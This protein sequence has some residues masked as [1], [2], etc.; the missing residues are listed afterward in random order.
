MEKEIDNIP[1]NVSA[2]ILRHISRGI[3]RTPAGA[4]KELVSNAHDAGAKKI[5]INTDFP[6]FEKITITDNGSGMSSDNFKLIISNIGLSDK[7][8]G[9]EFTIPGTNTKRKV[10]GHYGIG[11]LAIG[12]LC[13][14]VTITSKVENEKEGFEAIIDF[15][16]FEV[17]KIDDIERASIKDETDLET[18]DK[19]L[20]EYASEK[21]KKFPI[22]KCRITK[23]K[24]NDNDKSEHFTRLELQQVR[25]FVQ[26]KLSGSLLEKYSDLY[27]EPNYSSNFAKLLQLYRDKEEDIR[28]GQYPYEKLCW[29]LAVY[30]PLK[31]PV[32][33]VFDKNGQ[34][35]Y[36]NKIANA[37]NFE[38]IIDALELF[39]PLEINLFLDKEFPVRKIFVWEKEEYFKGK[40]VSGY[41]VYRQHIRPKSIQGILIR[42][43]GVAIGMYDST[44]LEYPY[45]EGTK[46]EQL[47]GEL[48]VEGLSSALNIDRNSFNETDDYYLGL[49][50]WFHRKLHEEVFPSIQKEMK[51]KREDVIEVFEKSL[52][53]HLKLSG[54][55][56]IVKVK[57][58]GKNY[59]LF[60]KNKDQITINKALS[61]G[62]L[63]KSSLEKM[64]LATLLIARNL[65]T[66][67]QMEKI[68]EDLSII[69]GGKYN[70]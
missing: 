36:F 35:S 25:G 6:I 23:L 37:H 26:K 17:T 61:L 34:L 38:L 48:F 54:K 14:T 70:G 3:Y 24:Y 18:K 66:P 60:V 53:K 55:N 9:R 10:I 30:S 59:P 2:R 27:L 47:T 67:E 21:D 1:I 22:G 65:I 41:M 63:K 68:L 44:F 50:E 33:D 8:A 56:R 46:F 4:L 19:K 64:Y 52:N 32:L 51:E 45:H 57:N 69:S 42:E 39:K 15:D 58:L 20:S 43:A 5:T 16:D 11:M 12:Q 28:R 13:K 31:Y 49:V 40:T 62:R 7:T 29:E